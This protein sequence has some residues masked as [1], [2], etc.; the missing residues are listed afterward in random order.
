MEPRERKWCNLNGGSDREITL[1]RVVVL[2]EGHDEGSMT[3]VGNRLRGTRAVLSRRW[4]GRS[5]RE[6]NESGMEIQ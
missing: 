4:Q 2:D 5:K 3:V 1:T 6:V